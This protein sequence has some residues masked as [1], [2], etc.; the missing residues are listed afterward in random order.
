MPTAFATP[1][2]ARPGRVTSIPEA[3]AGLYR[4]EPIFTIAGLVLLA[5]MVPTAMAGIVDDRTLHGIDIWLKPLKFHFALTVYLLTLAFYARWLP[6]G[7]TA[8]TGY[9]FYAGAVVAAIA[10]ETLWIS[11]AAAHGVASHF[12]EATPLMAALY[13][14]M[15]VLAI[16]LTSATAVY[17]VAIARNPAAHLPPAGRLALVLGLAL[18]LPLTLVTALTLAQNGGHW[19]GGVPD[20]AGGL[21][22]MGWS[23]DGG[24]LRV[25]HFFATHAMHFLPAFGLVSIR[26]F[27]PDRRWPVVAFAAL[28]TVATGLV[29]LQALSGQPFLAG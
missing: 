22:L 24:D 7:M 13:S 3:L 21:P 9:R 4:S 12:N 10:A 14:V 11:G 20:D 16:L 28:Y 18:V 2:A 19:V 5:A 6:A 29:F 1:A 27:G 23:R 17:A 25:A 26:L 8:R 15:G